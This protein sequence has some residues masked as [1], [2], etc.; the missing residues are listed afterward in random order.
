MGF[1]GGSCYASQLLRR[2]QHDRVGDVPP[3]CAFPVSCPRPLFPM[4][5][6]RFQLRGVHR[7]SSC[8]FPD[9][10]GSPGLSPSQN[11]PLSFF[12][13]SFWPK[14]LGLD[15]RARMAALAYAMDSL[16]FSCSHTGIMFS[17][18]RVIFQL[19]QG[20]DPWMVGNGLSYG[21]RLGE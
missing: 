8:L 19:Q 2:F 6:R 11:K 7:Q 1:E 15:L 4:T 18:P 10:P 21:A 5:H 16:S 20:E 13:L 9:F 3:F 14:T 12:G 17:K